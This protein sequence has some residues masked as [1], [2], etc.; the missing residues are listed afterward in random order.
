MVKKSRKNE[1]DK[2][3]LMAPYKRKK[4]GPAKKKRKP[5]TPEQ[6]FAAAERLAKAREAKGPAKHKN[7][8]KS[9]L[10]LPDDHFL[11]LKKV[12][13]W[14]KTQKGIVSSERRNAHRNVKGAY[15]R[16]CAAEGYIRFM[17][18]YIQH[19][20]WPGDYYGEYEDKRIKWKT[21]T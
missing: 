17:N 18:H 6:R 16:Q 4:F 5:M 20:D 7:I 15:A 10:E 1:S 12:R 13:Q 9:V 3:L 11:S 8:S 14:I 21:I 2:R 19:G